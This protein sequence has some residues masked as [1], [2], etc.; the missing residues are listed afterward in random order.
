MRPRSLGPLRKRRHGHEPPA[1][2][3]P[4]RS[5][6]GHER[7]HLLWG[8]PMLLRLAGQVHLHEHILREPPPAPPPL[9]PARPSISAASSA[10]S[11]ACT[12][13]AVPTTYL[14]LFFCSG[15]MKC[16]S[17]AGDAPPNARA[18]SRSSCA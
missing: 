12:S 15:P 5:Q 1:A 4:E 3:V 16:H 13:T 14:T 11:I 6:R 17:G 10:L 2:H 7:A 8:H 9:A 18:L